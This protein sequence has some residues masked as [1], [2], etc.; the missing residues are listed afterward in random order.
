[1][2][3]KAEIPPLPELAGTIHQ[4]PERQRQRGHPSHITTLREP[5]HRERS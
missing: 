1:M 5:V 2:E 3:T 4:G